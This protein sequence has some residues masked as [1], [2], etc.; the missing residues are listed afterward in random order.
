MAMHRSAAV[1]LGVITFVAATAGVAGRA[2]SQ[3]A[4]QPDTPAGMQ[5]MMK[6]HEQMMAEMKAGHARLDQLLQEMK[7]AT[8]PAKVDAVAAAV[9]ELAAQHKAMHEHMGTMHGRMMTMMAGRA[10]MRGR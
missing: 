1:A 3:E 7:G 4:A 9:A 5:M 10:M 6:M 2:L 8:G